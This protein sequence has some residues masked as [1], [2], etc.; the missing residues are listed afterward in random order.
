MSVVTLLGLVLDV[1]DV[2]GNT[3]IA[4]FRSVVDLVERGE[5]VQ[6]GVLVVQHLGDS[7]SGSGFTMV[8]VTDG[9]DVYVRLGLVVLGL[10]HFCPPGTRV[11]TLK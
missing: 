4:L 2:N 6:I 10:S 7:C 11:V 1:G 8:N 9:A 3:T 5:L